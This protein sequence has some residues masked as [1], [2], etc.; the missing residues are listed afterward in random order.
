[1]VN[2]LNLTP[3]QEAELTRMFKE[4]RANGTIPEIIWE[5]DLPINTLPIYVNGKVYKRFK[6]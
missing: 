1:M 5:E 2:D 3:A 4:G 6:K